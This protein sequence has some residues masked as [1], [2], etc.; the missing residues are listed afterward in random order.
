MPAKKAPENASQSLSRK[1]LSFVDRARGRVATVE[2]ANPPPMD[3]DVCSRAM[4]VAVAQRAQPAKRS[5]APT[6]ACP[7]KMSVLL[8]SARLTK[9]AVPERP[10]PAESASP[11]PFSQ[12]QLFVKNV[13]PTRTAREGSARL[14]PKGNTA[15]NPAATSSFV[16]LAMHASLSLA[17]TSARQLRGSAGAKAT[18]IATLDLPVVTVDACARAVE[19]MATLATVFGVALRDID[20]F[21]KTAKEPA[22]KLVRE[23]ILRV[24]PEQLVV[25]V[26]VV[27]ASQALAV[28]A[29]PA[30]EMFAFVL[31]QVAVSASM[32]ALVDASPTTWH[33]ATVPQTVNAKTARPAIAIA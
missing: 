1:R 29:S 20:A 18:P 6:S 9:T 24:S 16:H 25:A 11:R 21:S 13:A 26:P 28:S 27:L 10:A 4:R 33:F 15:H 5:V 3:F 2:H 7:I 30:S 14:I 8:G 12:R 23:P 31:A 32:E 17:A 19:S 22:F